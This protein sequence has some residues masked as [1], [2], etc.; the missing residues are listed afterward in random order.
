MDKIELQI[1]GISS[2]HS[3]ASYTLILEEKNGNKKLPVVIGAPEAQAIAIQIEKIVPPRP[4]TH[5]L[6]KKFLNLSNISIKEVVIHKIH[7]GVFYANIICQDVNGTIEEIDARTSDAIAIALRFNCPIFTYPHIMEEAGIIL[8][9]GA[10]DDDEE[11]MDED[12]ELPSDIENPQT[13]EEKIAEMSIDELNEQLD[14]A[15][16]SE[17]YIL[18]A[19]I[20]DE[21]NRRKK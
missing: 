16:D 18:A 9:E 20:R 11:D 21:I 13:Q 6:F 19:K 4:M 12:I 14:Q 2:G 10:E 5:D 8:T 15:I 3:A 7:E 1:L 17:N